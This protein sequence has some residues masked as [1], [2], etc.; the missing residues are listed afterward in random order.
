MGLTQ[1]R[2]PMLLRRAVVAGAAVALLAVGAG[3]TLAASSPT[4]YACFNVNGQVAMSTVP[5]CKLAGGG[6]LVAITSGQGPTGPVGPSGPQGATGQ[7]GP[8]G[9]SDGWSSERDGVSVPNSEYETTVTAQIA[10]LPTGNY[11]VNYSNLAWAPGGYTGTQLECSFYI[12]DTRALQG[13]ILKV[14]DDRVPFAMTGAFS[15]VSGHPTTVEI[16]CGTNN[17][18]SMY[19]SFSRLTLIRVGTLHGE[20]A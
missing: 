5:Q 6:Q 1:V 17:T 9:P 15:Y 3:G 7:A 12:G 18:G 4:V 14:V 11:I 20:T 10:N 19:V 8:T 16:R 13:P 2:T